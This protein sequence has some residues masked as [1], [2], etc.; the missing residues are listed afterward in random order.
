MMK[1]SDFTDEEMNHAMLSLQNDLKAVND[2]LSGI[3]A[4]YLNQIYRCDI[5]T[6]EQAIERYRQVT[7][8]RIVKAAQSITLDTVY[9]LTD[10]R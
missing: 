5:I 2:S 3:K 1:A 9:V 7:R 6:P 10:V 4:W 8:E